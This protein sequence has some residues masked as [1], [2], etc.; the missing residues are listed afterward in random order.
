MAHE[1]KVWKQAKGKHSAEAFERPIHTFCVRAQVQHSC[2]FV[3]TL[4]HKTFVVALRKWISFPST[5]ELYF[6]PT[7]IQSIFLRCK[8]TLLQFIF[9]AICCF[10]H[11]WSLCGHLILKLIYF[12]KWLLQSSYQHL[13]TKLRLL[14]LFPSSRSVFTFT[15]MWRK[16]LPDLLNSESFSFAFGLISGVLFCRVASHHLE[17]EPSQKQ[18]DGEV[19]GDS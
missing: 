19:L 14:P 3:N 4:S 1:D 11:D 2:T 17:F 8:L 10:Y 18:N 7:F 15:A 5:F 12:V 13:Y 9:F 6:F 16:I